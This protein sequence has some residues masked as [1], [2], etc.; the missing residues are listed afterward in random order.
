MSQVS[1][2]FA[3]VENENV[4][5]STLASLLD[6]IAIANESIEVLRVRSPRVDSRV[7]DFE[8]R[9]HQLCGLPIVL[10]PC[11]NVEC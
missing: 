8:P 6:S 3:A 7:A 9:C 4:R 2:L 10:A 5:H 1:C 11:L